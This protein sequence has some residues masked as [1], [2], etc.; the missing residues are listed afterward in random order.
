MI[1]AIENDKAI[2][3]TEAS[4]KEE[5]TRGACIIEDVC[6]INKSEGGIASNQWKY[7]TAMAAEAL[8]MLD[9][10]ATV[11]NNLGATK[12]GLLKVHTDC[13]VTCDN[14]MLDSF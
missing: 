10:V 14:L 5:K 12:K 3:T 13:K 1:Q 6:R 11:V 7:N 9:L 8:T 2:N 4:G